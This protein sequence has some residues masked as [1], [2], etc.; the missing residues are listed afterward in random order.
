MERK[1]EAKRWREGER[2]RVIVI[3]RDGERYRGM[4]RNG[5]SDTEGW[6]ESDREGWRGM[7]RE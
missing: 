5:E 3:Q 2:Y 1:S 4:E 6:R 7:M